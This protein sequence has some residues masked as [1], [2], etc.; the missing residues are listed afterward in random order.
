MRQKGVEMLTELSRG[1]IRRVRA[2]EHASMVTVPE[3]TVV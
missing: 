2:P 1:H 3:V